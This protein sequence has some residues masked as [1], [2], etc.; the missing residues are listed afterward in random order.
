MDRTVDRRGNPPGR[1]DKTPL[2]V[3][4]IAF[5]SEHSETLV[6]LDLEYAHLAR[7]TGVPYV[8]VPTVG[9][10]RAFI[11]GLADMVKALLAEKQPVTSSEGRRICAAT[12]CCCLNRAA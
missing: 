6:E 4:P 1:T 3:V 7:D 5:V 10:Q 9:T 11:D 12:A 2:V 8:R